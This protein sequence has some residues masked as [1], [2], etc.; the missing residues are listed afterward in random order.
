[1][2]IVTS[3]EFMITVDCTCKYFGDV[4]LLCKHCLRVLYLNHITHIPSTYIVKRWT[5]GA[6]CTRVDDIAL[7]HQG[8]APLS[9]WRLPNIRTFI[10]IVDRAQY[11]MKARNVIEECIDECTTRFKFFLEQDDENVLQ[12][13]VENQ[14][15][16][17]VEN[18]ENGNLLGQVAF[19]EHAET[20]VVNDNQQ[21]KDSVMRRKKRQKNSRLK[22][23]IKNIQV[24]RS[25]AQV[26][27]KR[28]QREFQK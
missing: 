7:A 1:M 28:V 20:E 24:E 22:H 15:G 23:T 11:D 9:V 21:V 12:E 10:C 14:E 6:T 4:G 26:M 3:D 16:E 2:H 5:K 19:E 13:F 27:E 8:I 18:Q 17:A 25:K